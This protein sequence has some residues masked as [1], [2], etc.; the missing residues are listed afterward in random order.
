LEVQTDPG[1][2]LRHL[3]ASWRSRAEV[4]AA[5]GLILTAN[6]G[7]S[8]HAPKERSLPGSVSA[9]VAPLFEHGEGRGSIGCIAV[10]PP[11]F[12]SEEEALQIIREELCKAGLRLSQT[13]VPVAGVAVPVWGELPKVRTEWVTGKTTY[14]GPSEYKPAWGMTRPFRADL[15]SDDGTFLIEFVSERDARDLDQ[16]FSTA[17]RLDTKACAKRT[18]E[19]F[20]DSAKAG[21]LGLMYDP[22]VLQDRSKVS[23]WK[24]GRAAQQAKAESKR[25]LRLQVLDFVNWLKAQ[26]AI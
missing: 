14:S 24:L 8:K 3:P 5:L 18:G 2:L 22:A 4:A 20:R 15:A 10:S 9:I 12:L 23:I 19:A 6:G 16:G 17:L 11:A 21:M 1:L 26:G 25:L 7:C 13:D